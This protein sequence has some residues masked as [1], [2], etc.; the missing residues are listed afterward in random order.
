MATLSIRFTGLCVFVPKYDLDD[1]QF[2]GK[3]S[4]KMLF[5]DTAESVEQHHAMAGYQAHELHLPLLICPYEK[6]IT[7]TGLRS[8]DACFVATDQIEA[9]QQKMAVFYLDDQELTIDE[10][11]EYLEVIHKSGYYEACPTEDK[12]KLFNWVAPLAQVCPGSELIRPSCLREIKYGVDSAV[13]GRMLL[14]RGKIRTEQMA[15]DLDHRIIKWRFKPLT[16]SYDECGTWY[17]QAIADTVELEMNR[18]HYTTLI[19]TLLREPRN[20]RIKESFE[21]KSKL[22]IKLD[23]TANLVVW[24]K[25]MP[26]P[27]ATGSR[28][29]S[30]RSRQPDYHFAH[31]YSLS[32]FYQGLHVP[33]PHRLCD[34]IDNRHNGN[35]NC[36]PAVGGPEIPKKPTKPC[37]EA[38]EA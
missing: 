24:V 2:Y 21:Q 14:N 20:P 38:S 4:M 23:T 26:W 6:V 1:C 19:A 37:P 31:F 32:R 17:E 28:R 13:L 5:V 9:E 15:V 36:P 25:N 7:G 12:L 33:F 34:Q 16:G 11:G 18:G 3:N 30:P 10:D 29:G 35:P 8:P 22:P 27:D